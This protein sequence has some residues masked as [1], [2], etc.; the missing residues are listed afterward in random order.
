MTITV[1]VK[2]PMASGANVRAVVEAEFRQA[3]RDAGALMRTNANRLIYRDRGIYE[4]SW[5][6]GQDRTPGGRTIATRREQNTAPHAAV[7]EEGV[8]RGRGPAP[9]QAFFD[10][11]IRR[12]I[13]PIGGE[14]AREQMAKA[15]VW[16]RYRLGWPHPDSRGYLGRPP[17]PVEGALDREGPAI[18]ATYDRA[19]ARIARRLS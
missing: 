12:G 15:M 11:S 18:A 13:Q 1:T 7:M 17:K 10:W 16:K 6:P 8:G 19:G 5:Q 2:G 3:N 9:W 14:G 4:G